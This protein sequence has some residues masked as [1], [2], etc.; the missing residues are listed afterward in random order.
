[1]GRYQLGGLESVCR[2]D[3]DIFF[4]YSLDEFWLLDSPGF[5]FGG[6]EE[7]ASGWTGDELSAGKRYGENEIVIPNDMRVVLLSVVAAM[8]I[9]QGARSNPQRRRG[10][11]ADMA[12]LQRTVLRWISGVLE[13][14]IFMGGRY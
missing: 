1:M 14:L 8:H 5:V 10:H 11:R 12:S 13:A 9:D 4:S 6:S 2:I 7:H 3:D